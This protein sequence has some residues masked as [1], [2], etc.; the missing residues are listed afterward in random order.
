[1]T[2]YQLANTQIPITI[3][4]TTNIIQPLYVQG[5]TS[6]GGGVMVKEMVTM[7]IDRSRNMVRVITMNSQNEFSLS[8]PHFVE[9]LCFILGVEVP[10]L[11]LPEIKSE[12]VDL[13]DP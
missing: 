8:D 12:I 2:Y 1:M 7:S 13:G 11:K 10:A 3:T 6:I 4:T 5:Q 9:K